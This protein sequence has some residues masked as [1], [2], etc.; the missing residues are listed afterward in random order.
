[1]KRYALARYY[2][3][4]G[5]LTRAEQFLAEARALDSSNVSILYG[6]AQLHA[7]ARRTDEALVALEEA[8][9]AGYPAVLANHDPEF[10]EVKKDRR[11]GRLIERYSG[12][13]RR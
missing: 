11:F 9:E 5:E 3:R 12:R 13:S 10:A 7:V 2:A 1:M 6:A 8:F 4:K